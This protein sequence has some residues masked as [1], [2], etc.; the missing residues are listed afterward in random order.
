MEGTVV[1]MAKTTDSESRTIVKKLA[2]FIPC[3]YIVYYLLSVILVGSFKLNYKEL[4]K[5]PFRIR[6][7]EFNPGDGGGALG[8]WLA[9]VLTYTLTLGLTYQI[10]RVT[11]KSW[12]Y[13]CTTTIVH[14]LLCII[15]N[16]AFPVNWIWWITIVLSTAAVSLVSEFVIHKFREMRDIALS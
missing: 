14:W 8:A 10:V 11:R 2:M 16:Q 9:M 15:V 13:V 7:S 5:Y 4:G 6:L 1:A 3:F 12:D